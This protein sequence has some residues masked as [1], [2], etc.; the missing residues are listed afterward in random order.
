MIL[1]TYLDKYIIQGGL[2]MFAL[3][4][5]SIATLGIIIQKFLVLRRHQVVNEAFIE[6][7]LAVNNKQSMQ[8]FVQ[9]IETN[10]SILGN[11]IL[12]YIAAY[13]KNEPVFPSENM[14][15][16]DD[17][18]DHLYQS[19]HPISTAYIIAPLLG[20]LGTTVGIMSTFEQ[21]AISGKRDM[22]LLV[23]AINKSLVTTMWGLIIAVPA[24]FCYALLQQ[25]IFF[26]ERK[27]L[28]KIAEKLM[29]HLSKYL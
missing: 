19:L 20:V 4:P 22:S 2:T 15:P 14:D 27:V 8:S 1:G 10:E 17:E 3:V 11:I 28:P 24:Y 12:G 7:A 25:K 21:F 13:E 9:E 16:I 18:V 29:K 23:G 26:Y 5:L 6:K